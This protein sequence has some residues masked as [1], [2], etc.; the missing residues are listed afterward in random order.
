MN[1]ICDLPSLL[2]SDAV[3]YK[4]IYGSRAF[5][6]ADEKSDTDIR[7]VFVLPKM[8]YFGLDRT[9]QLSDERSN[10]VYWELDRFV[11]LL[12]KNNPN[13]LEVLA[14]SR[15]FV[16]FEDPLFTELRPSLFLSKLSCDTFAN[17][18]E[19]QLKKARGLNKK[20]V[21]PAPARPESLLD[22]CHVLDG[23]GSVPV[24]T[25]LAAKNWSADQCGLSRIP[26]MPDVYALFRSSSGE[27]AGLIKSADSGD[28]TASSIP[29][30]RTPDGILCFNRD[31]FR[32]ANKAHADFRSWEENRNED[33]YRANLDS[34]KGYD[35][36]NLM[37]VFRLIEMAERIAKTGTLTTV[38]ADREGLL[39]IKRGEREYSELVAEATQRLELVRSDFAS[40]ALPEIPNRDRILE[41]LCSIRDRYYLR[42]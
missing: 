16:L 38:T 13:A 22:F 9:E 34:G 6:L 11:T 15:E 37:H 24:L 18:A 19:T 28:L 33:R 17:Y 10:E 1:V 41:I 30:G 36:K 27:F 39:R 40:S 20:I 4:T 35:T 21:N 32:R 31:E 7:G 23:Y 5:G 25:W 42:R 29:P 8:Q 26:H 3:I 2:A 14:T 12:L